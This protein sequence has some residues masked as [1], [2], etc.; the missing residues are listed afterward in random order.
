MVR[1]PCCNKAEV[2]RGA[3]AIEEDMLLTEYV[4][5]HGEGKWRALP[6]NA[7]LRR[8]GKSCRLRWFNYLRPGIKRGNVSVEEEDLIIELHKKFGSKWSQIA[9]HLPGRT[10]NE[11][12]NHW[13]TTIK[14]KL[15]MDGTKFNIWPKCKK[16]RVTVMAESNIINTCTEIPLSDDPKSEK[17]NYNHEDIWATLLQDLGLEPKD[18]MQNLLDTVN[19]DEMRRGETSLSTPSAEWEGKN[20]SSTTDSDSF[21][22]DIDEEIWDLDIGISTFNSEPEDDPE[23]NLEWFNWFNFNGVLK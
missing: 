9:E 7:G 15:L 2:R 5:K 14:R 18:Q 13:N 11:I 16:P 21:F 17:E 19:G 10:D 22:Y 12:K 20:S 1:K 6:V 3:W 23:D 4:G 8:C